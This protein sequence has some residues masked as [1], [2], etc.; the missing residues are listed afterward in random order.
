MEVEIGCFCKS[1]NFPDP[2]RMKFVAFYQ[3]LVQVPD[4][5]CVFGNQWPETSCQFS[6]W[7]VG[8][9]HWISAVTV[10]S[11]LKRTQAGCSY[12][13]AR[14]RGL[15]GWHLYASKLERRCCWRWREDNDKI[16]VRRSVTGTD[17]GT[18]HFQSIKNLVFVFILS[19]SGANFHLWAL[20]VLLPVFMLLWY[21]LLL[22]VVMAS[23]GSRVLQRI[24]LFLIYGCQAGSLK[25]LILYLC[26]KLQALHAWVY[27]RKAC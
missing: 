11:G 20:K 12:S 19:W 8:T 15:G 21:A 2:E 18:V 9:E 10:E 16:L 6:A 13:R 7:W 14:G 23:M 26:C 17:L 3:G 4:G 1:L 22:P 5:L 24:G 27:W 25:Q